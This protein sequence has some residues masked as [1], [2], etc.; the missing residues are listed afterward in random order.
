MNIRTHARNLLRKTIACSVA[1]ALVGTDIAYAA[2]DLADVPLASSST[3]T[4]R[5]N[6]LYVLDDSGSMDWLSMPDEMQSEAD[7]VAYRTHVCNTIYYNPKTGYVAP[8]LKENGDKFPD[9]SFTSANSDGYSGS[10][11]VNLSTSYQVNWYDTAQPAYYY[12]LTSGSADPLSSACTSSPSLPSPNNSATHTP[13]ANGATWKKV[14]VSATSGPGGTDER[15][16]FANWYAYY[17]SRLQMMKASTGRAFV[18]LSG[19]YRVG[20]LTIN[21]NSPVTS[22]KYLKI[23]EFDSLQKQAFLDILYKAST[24]GSTPLREALSRAGWI[25][26]GQLDTGLTK[27]I[28]AADDPVQ[29][30]CQQNFTILTTDG[31]WNG[32]AGQKLDGTGLGNQ[33]GNLGE[34]ATGTDPDRTPQD[35]TFGVSPRPIWDGRYT[36]TK[37]TTT[38]T[39]EYFLTQSGCNNNRWQRRYNETVSV[40][41]E[42]ISGGVVAS[43]SSPSV[44]TNNNQSNLNCRSPAPTLPNPNPVTTVTTNTSNTAGGGAFDTL[45]DVAQYYYKT[46]LRPDDTLWPDKVPSSGTGTEDD[47]ATWQHMT[48]FT[49]GLG[50][51][52]TLKF[53]PDYK[54]STDKTTDFAQIR[55]GTKFWPDPAAGTNEKADDLWHTAVNGRGQAFNASN[56]DEIVSGLNAA[57]TGVNARVASAAAAATSNLEPV[58][59]DN[60]AFTASYETVKWQGEL[61]AREIDLKTGFVG[62]VPVWSAAEKLNAKTGLACDNRTIHLF[63]DKEASKL[64]PF[65]WNSDGCDVSGNPK[66]APET[67]LEA[68]E[69]AFFDSSYADNLSQ[70]VSMTDGTASTADQKTAATGATLV[71]FVRGQRGKERFLT[72]DINRLYRERENILGDIVNAQPLFIRRPF[73]EYID[74]GY[75]EYKTA[76]DG[77]TPMVYVAA[78]DGMLHAF[79][80]GK[81]KTDTKGGEE[82]WAFIPT[83]VLPNLHLLADANYAVLHQFTVDGTPV[84]GDVYDPASK[85]WR[86]VL[87]A[88]LNKGGQG[89]YALDVT[90]PE[91][92]K[93]LWEFK[94]GKCYDS[95]D[96]STAYADCNLGYSYGNPVITK[97]KD[98]TWVVFVTSGYNNVNGE[99]GDGEGFLYVLDA[100]T[101]RI[102][103]K[104]GTGVGD[105]TTPSGLGKV[106]NYVVS[107]LTDNTTERV[108]GADLLGNVWR[109]EVNDTPSV[110]LIAT[111]KDKDGNPQSITT[112]PELAN[113][114]FPPQPFVYVATGR[115][116]GTSDIKDGQVQS[117]YAIRD[118][119]TTGTPSTPLHSDLRASLGQIVVTNQVTDGEVTRTGKCSVT[120]GCPQKDGWFADW[121]DTGERVNVDVKLQLGTLTVLTNVPQN[122]ECNIGGYSYINFFNYASGLPITGDGGE[123]G[124]K[125]ADSLAVGLNI[126]RLP[127]GR[128][129]AISTTSDSTQR[130]SEVPIASP[131][132]NGRRV[133]WREIGE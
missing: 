123:L 28:P 122:T 80:A 26:A 13:S 120:D 121:P 45:A 106:N 47:K 113:V 16:N 42:R 7:R 116:L 54:T 29:Y 20:F 14:R 52:G 4:I 82:A 30:A 32:N 104:I 61:E 126:V 94:R 60:F 11:S 38:T 102:L 64:A 8:P 24:N 15:T 18:T 99:T 57:L 108:Y 78:N 111:A 49:L 66:G 36:Q 127:D 22:D 17:R 10:G 92:P 59:G 50:L 115:Y 88:G 51:F 112:K 65:K 72:G 25:F 33:D 12:L 81:D 27:G 69:Q 124:S 100:M 110:Q 89:Y 31:Y 6:I 109:F 9:Q 3:A 63:R 44:T 76:Q 85:T 129:V 125:L 107:G 67:T 53:T 86:T 101:G 73:A 58:A 74:T 77:R 79:Y 118:P 23:Q 71:N 97:L 93:G 40:V 37:T 96:S 39:R 133:S 41:T 19:A 131:S 90:D 70:W 21:P 95:A 114:G 46:D 2:V 119:M 55:A 35:I 68:A 34:T 5:P 1:M 132:I 84:A 98:G 105:A 130:T 43:T 75:K 91:N 62:T 56:P 128:T 103:N 117:I 48:T 87:V 83:M